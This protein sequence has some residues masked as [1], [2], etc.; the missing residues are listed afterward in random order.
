MIWLGYYY[1]GGRYHYVPSLTVSMRISRFLADHG[2]LRI[3]W[4]RVTESR[5][6]GLLMP[7]GDQGVSLKAIRYDRIVI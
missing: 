5:R 2:K 6:G 7:P 3:G 1:E 4:F